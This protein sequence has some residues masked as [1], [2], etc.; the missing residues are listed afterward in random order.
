MRTF[1]LA[2]LAFVPA[3]LVGTGDI[4]GGDNTQPGVCGDGT[5]NT[6]EACDDGNTTSG[7]GCSS[8]CQTE[9]TAPRVGATIDRATVATELHKTETLQLTLTSLNDFA[10]TVTLTPSL[11]DS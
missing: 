5:V 4:S 7:D 3:C 1:L 10:G 11:L 6:G 2:T 8:T 9:G